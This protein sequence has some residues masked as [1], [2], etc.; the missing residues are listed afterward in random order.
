MFQFTLYN[1]TLKRIFHVCYRFSDNE[2]YLRDD[3][4]EQ[5]SKDME[6]NALVFFND[7]D[8]SKTLY[9]DNIYDSKEK[10]NNT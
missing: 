2:K 4:S 6:E 1:F 8:P 7:E 5:L 3:S 10:S 9:N